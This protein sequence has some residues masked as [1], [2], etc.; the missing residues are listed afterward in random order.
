MVQDARELHGGRV[1]SEFWCLHVPE[2]PASSHLQFGV[3]P[4]LELSVHCVTF[5]HAPL[6]FIP[7]CRHDAHMPFIQA[8]TAALFCVTIMWPSLS[9]AVGA[10]DG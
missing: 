7:G 6:R 8:V 9:C 10:S 3:A 4:P 5:S 2:V 1:R